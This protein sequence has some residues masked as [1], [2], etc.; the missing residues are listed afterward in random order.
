MLQSAES[1][2]SKNYQALLMLS[3][4][5]DSAYLAYLLRE[6]YPNLKLLA[7]MVDNG[8]ASEVALL[9]ARQCA[10][11][12]GLDLLVARPRPSVFRD[13]FRYAFTHLGAGG[14]C[15]SV[16]FLDGELT[17]DIGRNVAAAMGIPLV[18]SALSKAQVE[19][20]L[21]LRDFRAPQ[22]WQDM[23]RE[24][25]GQ[26]L[27]TDIYSGPDYA[28]WWDGSRWEPSRR[29]VMLFPYYVWDYDETEIRQKVVEQGLVDQSR[30]NPLIT[31]NGLVPLML[32][33]DYMQQGFF[34]YEFEFARLI[35]EGKS[36]RESW[37]ML[38]EA[39]E[40]LVKSGFFAEALIKEPL[41]K[42]ALSR[43]ELGIAR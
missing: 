31:N 38:F 11:V 12:L 13:G 5:K 16:D 41:E 25:V 37:L 34:G 32:A 1:A 43:K 4:G 15:A 10:E 20:I 8:F 24:R 9:N 39:S 35:R 21:G 30:S 6:R 2:D 40:Y 18:I 7:L 26:Y 28:A 27:L 3:G 17:H 33:V 22:A 42:L 23:K 29:P 14:C 19:Q 36:E